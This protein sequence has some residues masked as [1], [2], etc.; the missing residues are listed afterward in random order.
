MH[1]AISDTCIY[2]ISGVIQGVDI[3]II[4]KTKLQ[5]RRRFTTRSLRQLTGH[6]I[7]KIIVR[8]I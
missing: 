6:S 5:L 8:H 1:D 7:I 2:T 4:D 3:N